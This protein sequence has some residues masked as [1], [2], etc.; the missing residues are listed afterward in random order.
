MIWVAEY[1]ESPSCCVVLRSVPPMAADKVLAAAHELQAY[2]RG[3]FG[4]ACRITK[5][6]QLGNRE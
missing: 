2:F 3:Y 5:R 6:Q 4:F 1:L